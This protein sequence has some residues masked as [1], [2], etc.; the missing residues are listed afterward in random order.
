MRTLAIALNAIL[1]AMA[2]YSLAQYGMS[3]DKSQIVLVFLVFS[4]PIVNT[5]AI[6]VPGRE[7]WLTLY[8]Q[9]K[10][11]EEKLRIES[12]NSERKT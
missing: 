1:L 6:L 3:Y 10:A 5:V 8:L 12:L 2:S 11:L 4:A 9:R 7:N